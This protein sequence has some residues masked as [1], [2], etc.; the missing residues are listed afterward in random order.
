MLRAHVDSGN[1]KY[2][3]VYFGRPMEAAM[4]LDS[5]FINNTKSLGESVRAVRIASGLTQAELSAL[6][7]VSA[8]FISGLEQGKPSARV[9]LV[10]Q[11]C[12]GLGIR[13]ALEFPTT[14]AAPGARRVRRSGR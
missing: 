4:P 13:V 14:P 12:E 7:G 9:G 2:A 10:L 3:F 1:L 8:P 11:V 5:Q 6:C